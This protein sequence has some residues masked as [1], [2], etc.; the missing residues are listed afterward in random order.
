VNTI[1]NQEG[2]GTVD[3]FLCEQMFGEIPLVRPGAVQF[4]AADT[5][6]MLGEVRVFEN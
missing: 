3:F 5:G 4:G 6:E 2:F 1:A